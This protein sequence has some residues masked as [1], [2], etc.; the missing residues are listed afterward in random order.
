MI[1]EHARGLLIHLRHEGQ[2]EFHISADER[3]GQ[4]NVPRLATIESQAKVG[5][6]AATHFKGIVH[7]RRKET[8]VIKLSLPPSVPIV[9]AKNT[10]KMPIGEAPKL[11]SRQKIIAIPPNAAVAPKSLRM[12]SFSMRN[13]LAMIM[14]RIGEMP[15]MT[16]AKPDGI[17]ISPQ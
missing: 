1:I 2:L 17:L 14:V 12:S 5:I 13:A 11:I 6:R 9:A 8:V 10:D 4:H 15:Y 16:A 3:I 7:L